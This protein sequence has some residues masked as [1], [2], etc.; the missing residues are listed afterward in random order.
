MS[1]RLLAALAAAVVVSFTLAGCGSSSQTCGT[2]DANAA[3]VNGACTCNSGFTGDGATCTQS[4][5]PA[6]TVMHGS[7]SPATASAVGATATYTCDTGYTLSGSATRTCQADATWSGTAP[8]CASASCSPDL[9]APANGSVDRTTGTTGDVAS[10]TCNQ[11]YT[12]SGN[13]TR[14]CEADG[15]WTGTAPTCTA[16]GTG[17][18]PN[19]CVHSAGC[20]PVGASGYSCGAC[21]MG[22]MGTNCDLPITCSGAAAP[23]NGA[24]SSDTATVGMSVTYTC[25]A[26]YTLNGNATRACQAD[27]TFAGTAPT[28]TANACAPDLTA[29]TNG[30]VSRTMGVTGDVATYSCNGGY[31]LSGN[32]TRTCQADGTWSGTAPACNQVTTG[33]NP[34]PC[35]HSASCTPMGSGGYSCGTCDAGWSGANCD[36]PVTCSGATAPANGTVSSASATFGNTITYSCNAGYTLTGM[37][38]R[39]CQASGTFSGTA[40]TCPPVDC[41]APPAVTNAGA[42][43]VSGGVGGAATTTFGA[44]AAYTCNGGYNRMGNNPTCGATGSWSTAPTC[45]AVASCGTYTDVVYRVTGTFAITGTLG[46]I[47]NQSFT[48]LTNNASTP[49]FAGA[50]NSTPFSRPPPSGGTTFTNGF[51]RLRYTNDASGRPGPGTVRLVEWYFPMEFNQT[52]GASLTVNVDHSVGLLAPG[53]SNCGGGDAACTNHAPTL[54]RTCASNATGNFTNTAI[55][56]SPCTPN[57]S[58]TNSWNYVSARATSGAGCA[59]GYNGWGTVLCNTNCGLVPAAGKGDS[60]QTWNQQLSTIMLS[61]TDPLTATV[62]MG[63]MQIPNGTGQSQTRV[64]ITASTVV[65][66]QCGSTPG[67]DLTCTA[68]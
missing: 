6:L 5:C 29:P 25:T 11:G 59:T 34:N 61:G 64:S 62:T 10:Y 50:G 37:A 19:P 40:P 49:A 33:C 60:F 44:T 32:A 45:V 23:A 15:T 26:G 4:G 16:V 39:S 8:T 38:T 65:T 7:V 31:A 3:C 14:S 1:S 22:Y 53:L 55:T 43:T 42:P 66:T 41:G 27:G 20:T 56:W 13:A 58:G 35:V 24:V 46:G 57:P 54:Q 68:Q 12:L 48:G 17:C 30:Q 18:T 2:C 9:T 36:V 51:L 21:D 63:A 52:A 47:G 28:C 67:V